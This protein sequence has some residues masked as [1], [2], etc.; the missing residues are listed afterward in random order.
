M[1]SA[2]QKE[3]NTREDLIRLWAHENMRVYRDRLVDNHDRS[4]FDD[5][6]KRLVPKYFAKEWGDVV[7]VEVTH[8]IYGDFMVPGADPKL[9]SEITDTTKM[10]SIV[11]EYLEDY[12]STHTKKMPL[13]MFVDAVSHVA[14]ISRVIRQP[15][16]N[17]L[18]LCLLY[19]SP[20]PRDRTRS[21]MPSSA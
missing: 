12:N 5:L 14:R 20:S 1:L 11:E 15:L 8:L 10:V 7:K 17:Q 21:R 6:E 3:I 19:T 18:S 13:V 4:W 9:Y 16:G 2:S